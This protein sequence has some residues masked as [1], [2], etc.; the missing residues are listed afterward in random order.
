MRSRCWPV[1][2]ETASG[3]SRRWCRR[4]FLERRRPLRAAPAIVLDRSGSMQGAPLAQAK[5]AIEACL[6]ALSGEDWF[7]MVA[8][9]DRVE[10]MDSSLQPGSREH[11][12]RA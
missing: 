5:K 9:D 4:I 2:R 11:R 6:A 7:G 3:I 12:E 1:R 8:F 10:T